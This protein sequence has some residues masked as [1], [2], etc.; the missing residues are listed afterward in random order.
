[1]SEKKKFKD[2]KIGKFLKNKAP[3]ILD[4]IGNVL[5]DK[6][7][8]G[9][10]KNLIDKDD[11]IDSETKKELHNQLIEAY[12]TEVADR[13]SARKREVEVAKVKKFD[14]M[15]TLTGLVGLGTFVFLVYTIVYVNIPEN[16]E[17][18]FYTL[19]GLCEGIVLSIFGFYF[20]SSLRKN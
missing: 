6:G 13:D 2:T 19:I 20:G 16:N 10:V 5:P 12:K 15:F 4:V 3:N 14:L 8:L 18:T 9:I 7:A 1:M 11:S 17:K